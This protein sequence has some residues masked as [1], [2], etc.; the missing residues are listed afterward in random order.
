MP[1]DQL[2]LGFKNPANRCF[3]NSLMQT[4]QSSEMFMQ[5]LGFQIATSS[6]ESPTAPILLRLSAVLLDLRDGK[7]SLEK[8]YE[9]FR[10]LLPLDQ[11]G[12]ISQDPR[13]VYSMHIQEHIPIKLKAIKNLIC[14]ATPSCFSERTVSAEFHP[15]LN[16]PGPETDM[17]DLDQ[18]LSNTCYGT[19]TIESKCENC[20]PNTDVKTTHH[21]SIQ[22]EPPPFLLMQIQRRSTHKH[23]HHGQV[24][25]LKYL[26][27]TIG[28]TTFM[29]RRKAVMI[30]LH[31]IEFNPPYAPKDCFRN[32]RKTKHYI[33]IRDM[34]THFL[35]HNDG[36]TTKSSDK[37]LILQCGRVIVGV[38]YDLQT[39]IESFDD[40]YSFFQFSGNI[41][42]KKP[43]SH[44]QL[45]FISRTGF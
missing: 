8:T 14:A 39:E 1:K 12:G 23:T 28:E 37:S 7:K 26:P 33:T 40:V 31:S 3:L 36:V 30:H 13:E 29:Y 19:D 16:M 18:L 27:L 6:H 17:I 34:D 32:K 11:R 20:S 43:F 4:L 5:S 10:E 9:K 22:G 42:K 25:C 2:P 24:N 21:F 38:M 41:E 35:I 45:M 44:L 15:Q